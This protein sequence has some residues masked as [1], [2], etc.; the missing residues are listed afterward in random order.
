MVFFHF[1]SYQRR[2]GQCPGPIFGMDHLHANL[3]RTVY[4]MFR[5][6][7]YALRTLATKLRD[8]LLCSNNQRSRPGNARDTY[9]GILD[10]LQPSTGHKE[11]IGMPTLHI[12]SRSSEE[13][14]PKVKGCTFIVRGDICKKLSYVTFKSLKISRCHSTL[15]NRVS[16]NS[17]PFCTK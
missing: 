9:W 14:I 15:L 13:L 5:S 3:N 8:S 11:S 4:H 16:P 7:Q 2:P 10:R 12:G 6:M 1:I 17:Y